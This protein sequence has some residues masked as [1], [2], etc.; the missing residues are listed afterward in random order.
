[1]TRR[2]RVRNVYPFRDADRQMLASVDARYEIIHE[3]E[4]TQASVDGFDDPEVEILWA[5]SVPS[6]LARVPR[7]RWLSTAAAG[8][9]DLV[10][11][12]PWGRGLTVTNASGVHAIAMAEYVL[13]AALM[14]TERIAD[15]LANQDRR[16]WADVRWA[17]ASRGLRGRTALVVGYGSVGREVA[18]LLDACGVRILAVKADPTQVADTGWSESGTGDPPGAIPE[19][20]GGPDELVELA[21]E[22]DLLVLTMPGTSATTGLVGGQVLGALRPGAWVINVGRG[23]VIDEAA[24]LDALRTDRLG[25]AVL[26]V[27]ATEPLPPDHPLWSDPRCVI[28]P[29]VSGLGDVDA[30]WHRVALLFAEQLRRDAAGA[31]LLN[32][33]SG[34]RG[35]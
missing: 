6:D 29:H 19:R 21:R 2:V 35:Y 22:A 14:V 31:A 34:A 23:S 4:D 25:G 33:T 17:L 9:D 18:R 27:M 30:V 28:T 15:R 10:P 7:L 3:G 11:L 20:I 1:M 16:A 24:L 5:S 32:V 13:G 26:D 8:I 12:D